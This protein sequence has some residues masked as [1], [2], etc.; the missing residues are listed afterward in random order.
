MF[1]DSD[2]YFS[3][4]IEK[5]LTILC[6][7]DRDHTRRSLGEISQLSGINKTSTF[8]FV[9]TLVKLGYLKKN[10]NNKLLKLGPKA[11]LLG[12]NFIQ[13]FDLLQAVKPLIDKTFIEHKIT[14]DSA[15][16]DDLTLLSLYRKEAPNI[17]HFRLPLVMQ[18]LHARAMGKAVLAQFNEA[19]LVRFFEN[20]PMKK[21]TPNTLDKK[22]DLLRE[23]KLTKNRGYSFNNEEYITGLICMGAPLMNY[24]TNAVVGAISFDFPSAEYSLSLIERNYTGIL[25]KLAG[26]ISEMITSAEN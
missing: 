23:L 18:E 2:Q 21:L 25:T 5:G 10:N 19:Q 26:D 9:N 14:I 3:K 17:I 15:L 22:E 8:R 4:T 6:L 16:L 13:G 11:L 24:Q 7:F 20:V 12:N 1:D